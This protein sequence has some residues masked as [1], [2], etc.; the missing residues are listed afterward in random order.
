MGAEDGEP[1]EHDAAGHDANAA[2]DPSAPAVAPGVVLEEPEDDYEEEEIVPEKKKPKVKSK[3][4]KQRPMPS[5]TLLEFVNKKKRRR[6]SESGS[7]VELEYG[8][9]ERPPSPTDDIDRRRS[10]RSTKRKKYVDEVD[11]NF[12]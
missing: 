1:E 9:G 12:S 4:E 10:G 2:N 3:K 11:Y 7:D 5:K 6:G 8:P